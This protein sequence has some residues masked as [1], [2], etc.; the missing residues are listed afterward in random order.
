VP[1][2]TQRF[3][4]GIINPV[5]TMNEVRF[6]DMQSDT[7]SSQAKLLT[8]TTFTGMEGLPFPLYL[9]YESKIVISV[10]LLITLFL[11]I[12]FKKVMVCFLLSPDSNGPINALVWFDQL[13]GYCL[14][15]VI[16]F[17][18]FAINYPEPLSQVVGDSF[19][20]WM[21]LHG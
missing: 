11:G 16:L 8:F 3:C 12:K 7:N 18:I 4:I 21:S 15:I 14:G 10:F 17:K 1:K 13:N 9:S 5:T 6:F 19:C 20:E 2:K